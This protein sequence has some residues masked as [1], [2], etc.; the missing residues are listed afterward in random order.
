MRKVDDTLLKLENYIKATKSK[1]RLAIEADRK[2]AKKSEAEIDKN[3]DSI[4][5]DPVKT[6]SPPKNK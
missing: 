3:K 6:D 1:E 4:V 2:K 5:P